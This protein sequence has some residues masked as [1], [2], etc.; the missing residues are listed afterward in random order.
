MFYLLGVLSHIVVLLYYASLLIFIC[1]APIHFPSPSCPKYCNKVNLPD[2][3]LP[4]S[5]VTFT[6]CLPCSVWN[7]NCDSCSK[8][9]LEHNGLPD[10]YFLYPGLSLLSVLPYCSSVLVCLFYGKQLLFILLKL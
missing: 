8:Y 9:V 6:Y 7:S 10:K 2:S 5:F 1:E 3:E 4:F